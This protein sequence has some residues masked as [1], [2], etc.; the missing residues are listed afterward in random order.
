MKL[1]STIIP[2]AIAGAIMADIETVC[3]KYPYHMGDKWT[4]AQQAAWVK[5]G[6]RGEPTAQEVNDF[7]K[8]NGYD[9]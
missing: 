3:H 5:Q 7:C 9:A 2:L 6:Y 8:E 4:Q 1:Y